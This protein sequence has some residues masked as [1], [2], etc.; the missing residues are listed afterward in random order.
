MSEHYTLVVID[1]HPDDLELCRRMLQDV[2]AVKYKIRDARNGNVALDLIKS[3]MP[4]CVLL[5]FSLPG[6][7]GVHVLKCIR[8]Q[9][10]DLPVI[11]LTHQENEAVVAQI[12]KE[13]AQ[14]YVIKTDMTGEALHTSIQL[15]I[16]SVKQKKERDDTES[17]IIRLLVI[18]D[19]EDDRELCRRTLQKVK[20]THYHIVEAANGDN[21]LELIEEFHPH[22]ILLDYFM[23]GRNGIEILKCIRARHPYISVIML[24]G[25]GNE[26][27]AVQVMKEGAQDYIKK[28]SINAESL[29]RMIKMSVEYCSLQKRVLEQHESLT[30]FT[31]A[32]AHDLKE[33]VRMINSFIELIK[34]NQTFTEK[35]Q[36]FFDFVI[37]A[38]ANMEKLIDMVQIYTQ[39]GGNN[40]SAEKE[41]VNCT[42]VLD[43]VLINL[44]KQISECN[45]RVEYTVSEQVLGSKVQLSQ[46]FQNIIANAL[47]YCDKSEPEIHIS[48]QRKPEYILFSIQDNG[49]GINLNYGDKVFEPFR[50]FSNAHAGSGLG[51]AICKKI[52]ESH[53]GKIW[54][55]SL[56]GRGTTFKFTLPGNE[57][58]VPEVSSTRKNS[59]ISSKD[60]GFENRTLAN[61]LLIEDSDPDIELAR[62]ILFEEDNLRFNLFTASNG[63][64]ALRFL[65]D[66]NNPRPDLILLDINMPVMGGFD[67]LR[68]IR[69][70]QLF[71]TLPII[72]C[73]TSTYDKDIESARKLSIAGYINKPPTL[74]K[75]KLQLHAVKNIFLVPSELGVELRRS[76]H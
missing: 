48:C 64:E 30:L 10:P 44:Q 55:E 56:P 33:P 25:Q 9:Y 23:P 21:G 27:V 16:E 58:K 31:H 28:A 62:I 72:I 32:L 37:S 29:H 67:F 71:P 19:N 34:K 68:C 63:E 46:V 7:D 24:T 65:Q 5:G 57:V 54:Y 8:D 59:L 4:H 40:N 38:A 43:A 18:D 61:V 41:L 49:P 42:Q 52:V 70:E 13:G 1:D 20:S 76:P 45:A 11:L 26:S 3:E 2:S 39:I 22:C 35:N 60:A 14:D 75:I 17:K 74:E 69:S 50:R 53:G 36:T 47:F 12:M 6:Q 66:E 15:V 51:L 73:S